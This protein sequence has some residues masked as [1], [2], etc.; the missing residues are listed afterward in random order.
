[1][2]MNLKKSK[3]SVRRNDVFEQDPIWTFL[4][5]MNV[6]SKKRENLFLLIRTCAF[7]NSSF[8]INIS[9]DII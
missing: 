3:N 2:V 4:G 9:L 6:V 7:E 8:K 5:G 1:M